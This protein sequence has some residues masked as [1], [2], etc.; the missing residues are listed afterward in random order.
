MRHR[1][2]ETP[3]ITT[4]KI[5]RSSFYTFDGKA[6]AALSHTEYH[7]WSF[8]GECNTSKF[9]QCEYDSDTY[10][11]SNDGGYHFDSF[12]VQ[13]RKSGAGGYA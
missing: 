6:I 11:Q 2:M 7:G 5:W 3:R 12:V 4:T 13:I 10:H 1:K 9:N 8:A